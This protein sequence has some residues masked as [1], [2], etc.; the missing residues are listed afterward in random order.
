M[1]IHLTASRTINNLPETFCLKTIIS[2]GRAKTG[3]LDPR[4]KLLDFHT[5]GLTT[6]PYV[7]MKET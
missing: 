6:V 2:Q 1:G 5:S 3:A 7:P 4:P